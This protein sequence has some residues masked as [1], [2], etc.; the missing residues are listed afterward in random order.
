MQGQE[1]KVRPQIG[2]MGKV[3][4]KGCGEEWEGNDKWM[5]RVEFRGQPSQAK[6]YLPRR[7]QDNSLWTFPPVGQFPLVFSRTIS[8][9]HI[10]D[11]SDCIQFKENV[12]CICKYLKVTAADTMNNM[13]ISVSAAKWY[14]LKGKNGTRFVSGS[15]K[16][17]IQIL[18]LVPGRK[19]LSVPL[20]GLYIIAHIAIFASVRSI[21]CTNFRCDRHQ[22]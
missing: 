1:E 10:L 4:L 9:Q 21:K 6:L 19:C 22:Q 11:L 5:G 15:G 3:E 13:L 14:I 18:D 8:P 20:L 7:V 2:G 16:K 17:Y 12:Q